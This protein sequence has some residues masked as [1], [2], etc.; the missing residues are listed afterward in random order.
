MI[1]PGVNLISLYLLSRLV[2]LC[3]PGTVRGGGETV[4]E[5]FID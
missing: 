2:L 3:G 4:H 5:F 1:L